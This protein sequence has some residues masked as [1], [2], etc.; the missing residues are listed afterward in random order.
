MKNITNKRDRRF[1][2]ALSLPTFSVYNMRSIWS[3]LSSL[4]EDMSERA[5][6]FSILAEVWE[7]K[8]NLKQKRK[9]EEML[10]R[11]GMLYFS[12]ARPGT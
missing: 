10:E 7:K 1:L 4:L 9:L 3:K 12:T 6:Y 5:N 8:E 2:E 11:K